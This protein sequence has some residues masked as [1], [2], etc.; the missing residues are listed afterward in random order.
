MY[1]LS[2][3]I[4]NV[5]FPLPPN[6]KLT[7]VRTIKWKTTPIKV[8]YWETSE[9]RQKPTTTTSTFTVHAYTLRDSEKYTNTHTHI[10]T[11]LS[12]DS[13]WASYFIF[14]CSNCLRVCLCVCVCARAYVCD[15]NFSSSNLIAIYSVCCWAIS[16]GFFYDWHWFC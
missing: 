16:K 15:L 9:K 5:I 10:D 14:F 4:R 13:V 3:W 8:E 6:P 11:T 12:C 7:N 2:V 1:C